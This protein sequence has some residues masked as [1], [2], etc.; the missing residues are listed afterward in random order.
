M[1][2]EDWKEAIMRAQ[3]NGDHL[4]EFLRSMPKP[5][6]DGITIISR[7]ETDAGEEYTIQFPDGVIEVRRIYAHPNTNKERAENARTAG[8]LERKG[9]GVRE[10]P[11]NGKKLEMQLLKERRERLLKRVEKHESRLRKYVELAKKRQNNS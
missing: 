11:L 1:D 3:E 7:R 4:N 6:V 8:L 9:R 10:P 2:P 5:R